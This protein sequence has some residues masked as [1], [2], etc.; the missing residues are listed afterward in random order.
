MQID[1]TKPPPQWPAAGFKDTKLGSWQGN[2]QQAKRS[3][4]TLGLFFR[5]LTVAPSGFR[6]Q[7]LVAYFGFLANPEVG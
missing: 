1:F 4:W 7:G 2:R 5:G 3:G 6:R